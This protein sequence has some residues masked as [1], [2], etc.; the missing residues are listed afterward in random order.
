[1]S[2][3]GGEE[4]SLVLDQSG[5]GLVHHVE[6]AGLA[7]QLAPVRLDV[8]SDALHQFLNTK[9]SVNRGSDLFLIKVIIYIIDLDF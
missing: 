9:Q 8:C 7:G 2:S 4:G 5:A 1:M 3:I 6:V